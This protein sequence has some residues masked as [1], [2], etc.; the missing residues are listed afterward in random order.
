MAR[1]LEA[2]GEEVAMLGLFDTE[3]PAIEIRA[4][5][6]SERVSVYWN[7]QSDKPLIGRLASMASRLKDGVETHF[8]V[9]SERAEASNSDIAEANTEL[10]AVQLREAHSEVMDAFRPKPFGG[11]LTLFRAS[12]VNDKYAVPDDYGWGGVVGCLETVDVPGRH[13][14]LFESDNVEV[15]AGAFLDSMGKKDSAGAQAK[16]DSSC[17]KP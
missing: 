4:Y 6:L 13:L 7:A 12:V 8:R 2:G 3:N 11:T 9:R 16:H 14:T 17:R 10:R 15:L 5:P 1:L